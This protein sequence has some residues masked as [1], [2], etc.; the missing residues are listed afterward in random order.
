MLNFAE[1]HSVEEGLN[2]VALWNAAFL[3]S[4][5]LSTCSLPESALF[6]RLLIPLLVEAVGAHFQRRAPVFRNRL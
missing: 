4:E 3:Q 6:V 5:D 1:D 2:H